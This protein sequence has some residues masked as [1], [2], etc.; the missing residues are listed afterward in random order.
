MH[1][2]RINPLAL[3][4]LKDIKEYIS[5]ELDN[6]KAAN[7]MIDK[8]IN[9]YESLVNHPFIGSNLSTKIGINTDFRFLVCEK[10]ILFYKADAK[11]VYVYRILYGSRDYIRV[12]FGDIDKQGI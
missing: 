11:Y 6:P 10:Y 5:N 9:K 7:R 12:L 2:L 8:I 1:T 4:D 3:Q